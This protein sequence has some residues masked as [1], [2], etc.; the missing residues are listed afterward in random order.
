MPMFKLVVSVPSAPKRKVEM[1]IKGDT[2][3]EA[4]KGAEV[5]VYSMNRT[6]ENVESRWKPGSFY[7]R[8]FYRR[9]CVRMVSLE[10]L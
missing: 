5:K 1:L 6:V 7:K 4:L 3:E 8:I 2:L 10:I 9:Y